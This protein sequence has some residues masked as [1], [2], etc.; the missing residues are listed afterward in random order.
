MSLFGQIY[1]REKKGFDFQEACFRNPSLPY[2]AMRGFVIKPPKGGAKSS[3]AYGTA[4]AGQPG[5]TVDAAGIDWRFAD[6]S[7]D[8]LLVLN[9]AKLANSALAHGLIDQLAAAQV[10]PPAEARNVYRVL[11]ELG[12]VA[13]SVRGDATLVLVTGRAPDAILPALNANWKSAPVG[14]NALLI[15]NADSVA[16]ALQR[17]MAANALEELPSAAQLRPAEAGFWA[18]GFAKL[19]GKEAVRAGAK[20]FGLTASLSDHLTVETAFEFEAAPDPIAMKAWLGTLGDVSFEDGA[21]RV[22]SS[23]S[24]DEVSRDLAQIAESPFGL[25]LGSIISSARYLP[26]ADTAT[27]V[28]TKP[29]IF[30]LDDGPREVK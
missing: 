5:S 4:P 28:H 25:M 11:S 27:T 26:V 22:K 2:C 1:G 15:G 8:A 24:A 12:Q 9:C 6:P 23:K 18:A 3:G 10:V 21:V 7:A 16:P 14:E 30:G 29:V 19:A 20:E 13:V 17:L